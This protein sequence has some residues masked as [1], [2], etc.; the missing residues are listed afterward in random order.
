MKE[1]KKKELTKRYKKIKERNKVLKKR[2]T[3]ILQ[4]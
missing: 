4:K 3:K 2:R 1:K